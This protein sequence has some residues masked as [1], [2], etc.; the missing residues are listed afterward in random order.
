MIRLLAALIVAFSFLSL[1][2]SAHQDPEIAGYI[3]VDGGRIWYRLNGAEHLGKRPAIIVMHGGPGGT[4]RGN[5]PYVQLSDTYPVILYDQ[6]GTGNSDRT[7]DKSEWTVEHFVGEIDAIRKA[8]DLRDVV[9]AGHS[10]GGTLAAEYAVR[11]PEGLKA[12]ILSSPLIST[13]QW[14]ADNQEWIDQ[15]PAA[16]AATIRK[17]EA[18]GTTNAPEYRAAEQEFYRHH[19]C[20]QTPCPGQRYRVDGPKGNGEMYEYMWGP[21]EFFA[22]GTLKDYDVSPR[23]KD[24]NVPT[25]MVCGEFDEAAPKSCRRF[26][27][28]IDGSSTIIVPDAGHAT[29]AENEPMYVSA[30]RTFLTKALGARE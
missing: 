15:L 16:T 4:H 29:M 8:L 17:H 18:E 1:P 14:L 24:I 25:L 11:R 3:Q 30:V 13:H 10:W 9:I 12:A 7:A 19:M 22:P 27:G 2:A 20:R 28:M 6:L 21:T 5:M 26:A 23:L